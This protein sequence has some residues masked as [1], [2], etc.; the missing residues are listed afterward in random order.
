M[1]TSTTI[2][3]GDESTENTP[4]GILALLKFATLLSVAACLLLRVAKKAADSAIM[5][6]TGPPDVVPRPAPSPDSAPPQPGRWR[7]DPVVQRQKTEEVQRI[8][9]AAEKRVLR[10]QNGGGYHLR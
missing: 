4:L 9:A 10:I 7:G 6:I 3:R 1:S 5:L 8:N 2:N